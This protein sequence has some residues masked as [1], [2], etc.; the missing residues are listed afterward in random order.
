MNRSLHTCRIG[1][2]AAA[3]LLAGATA[4][5]DRDADLAA[6]SAAVQVRSDAMI[7]THVDRPFPRPAPDAASPALGNAAY[8]LAALWMNVDVAN[9]NQLLID[10]R[11]SAF[12]DEYW[13]MGQ[14]TRSYELF[15]C[16]SAFRP[17]RLTPAAEE[18]IEDVLRRH[19]EVHSRLAEASDPWIIDGSEN[20][21]VMRRSVNLLGSAILAADPAR[22]SVPLPDGFT[23]AEH[24]A[25][26]T[27]FFARYLQERGRKGL[28]VER[29]SPTYAK[30]TLQSIFNIRDF[31]AS[32]GVR[33]L[34]SRLLDLYFAD[35]SHEVLDGVRG[36]AKSRSYHDTSSAMGTSDSLRAYMH[37]I[38]GTPATLPLTQ[39]PSSLCAA[40]STYRLPR[41]ILDLIL[42]PEDK[43]SYSHVSR[44]PGRG[45]RAVP[46][47]PRQ[48]CLAART[49]A[50]LR[51]QHAPGDA[52]PPQGLALARTR[53][54]ADD[55]HLPAG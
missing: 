47:S 19:L 34:A 44:P 38:A 33:A 27:A 20:H 4:R 17:G 8:A 51:A 14:I 9:A 22:A 50:H 10:V 53:Q 25:A 46:L 54:H 26:W 40:T 45:T 42:H 28:F 32:P 29:G 6:V 31:A 49:A 16:D 52:G 12:A 5:A 48:A 2:F 43:G 55:R 3:L 37:L 30:Y 7:A 18:A 23:P 39:H 24:H 35:A 41:E 11:N 15:H 13:A 36:G 21:D 1:T